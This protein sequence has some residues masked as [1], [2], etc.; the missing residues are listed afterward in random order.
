MVDDLRGKIV[1]LE[2][3]AE[4]RGLTEAERYMRKELKSNLNEIEVGIK[5]DLKQK[6]RKK[7]EIE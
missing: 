3:M 5:M 4:V 1:N 2:A 7:L 6:A